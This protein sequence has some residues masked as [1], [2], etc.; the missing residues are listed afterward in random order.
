[1]YKISQLGELLGLSRTTLL[2]YEKLGLIRGQ[3]L[4][5]GYR[6]YS[7]NDLQRLRLI[8]K[9]Q[10]GGLTLKECQACL[11]EKVEREMLVQR[12][13]QLDKE[14]EE[15]QQ[16]R[17][18]LAALLG[19]TSLASWHESLDEVAP[20]A[21]LEWL[22]K[23]GFDEKQAL[24]LKWLS[25]DMNTHEQYMADFFRVFSQLERWGPGSSKD[26]LKALS[27]LPN[28]PQHLLEIGCGKG[29]STL[30][31]AENGVNQITAV[32]NEQSALDDFMQHVS[33]KG[34][35]QQIHPVCADMANLPFEP[36]SFD[37]VWA[38]GSAYIMGVEK[39]LLAWRRMLKPGG[40]LVVSDLVWSVEEPSEVQRQFWAKEYPDMAS[41]KSRLALAKKAGFKV[42]DHFSLSDEAWHNYYDPLAD[43]LADLQPEL[44]GSAAL[45][46]LERELSAFNSRN[47]EFDY[48]VFILQLS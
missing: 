18:L 24:H 43:T 42:L 23:Q 6:T 27:L 19:E 29:L 21:H 47:G 3:R 10:A 44:N 13:A 45:N 14:I 20:D 17:H 41:V 30:L 46:D 11:E 15:K 8:Q 12:L 39:A 48:Q 32:D 9:L 36:Q 34:F 31:F 26:T 35:Q 22:K 1:M 25:K 37:T 38:E 2:Y 4:A 7:D 16:S 5:N 28:T 33:E 40:I